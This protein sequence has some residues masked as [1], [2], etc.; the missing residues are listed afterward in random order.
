MAFF[1]LFKQFDVLAFLLGV[2]FESEKMAAYAGTGTIV[3]MFLI[4]GEYQ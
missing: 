1:T 3:V 2:F 4:C